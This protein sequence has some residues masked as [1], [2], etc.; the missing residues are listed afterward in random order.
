MSQ[1][2]LN[3]EES[4]PL[5]LEANHRYVR[6]DSR[7]TDPLV[8]FFHDGEVGFYDPRYKKHYHANGFTDLFQSKR[9]PGTYGHVISVPRTKPQRVDCVRLYDGNAHDAF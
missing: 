6:A 4:E 9:L 2:V 5:V 8:K 7:V 3:T 1:T